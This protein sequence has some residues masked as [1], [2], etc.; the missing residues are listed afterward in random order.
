MVI[1][2]GYISPTIPSVGKVIGTPTGRNL[3]G[4][5]D[6][7]YVSVTGDA[8]PG[9]KFYTFRSQD[10]K[11]KHPQT[12]ADLGFLIE[13]TGI[14]EIVG[15]ESGNA[16]AVIRDSFLDIVAHNQYG[17]YLQDYFEVVPPFKTASP[18]TPDIQGVIV[19]TRDRRVINAEGDI[20]YLDKGNEE[21][22]LPGDV[23]NIISGEYPHIQL[24][25]IVVI[26]TKE[27]TSTAFVTESNYEIH[28]GDIY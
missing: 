20:V 19:I 27:H 16:K 15:E 22:M 14:A 7:I 28:R 9:R 25:R 18:R 4:K 11:V 21:G 13:I 26:L 3:A 23:F 12:G 24:G 10:I 2:S 5:N 17:N 8:T 1:A 6:Y